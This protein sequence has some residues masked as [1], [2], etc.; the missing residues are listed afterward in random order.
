MFAFWASWRGY[1]VAASMQANDLA[2]DVTNLPL[3]EGRSIVCEELCPNLIELVNDQIPTEFWRNMDEEGTLQNHDR[4]QHILKFSENC[5]KRRNYEDIIRKQ[6]G[7]KDDE[8]VV[9]PEPG[10]Q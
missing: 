8:A 3:C 9:I 10:V 1:N 2:D 5:K 6:Q 7:L 4:W